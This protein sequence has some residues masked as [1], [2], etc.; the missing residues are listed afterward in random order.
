[1]LTKSTMKFIHIILIAFLSFFS[2]QLN[3]Q[4]LKGKIQNANNQPVEAAYIY[5]IN[6]TSHSHSSE[7]GV[8]VLENTRVGDSIKVGILGYE[9]RIITL[10]TSSFES[11]FVITLQEKIFQLDEMVLT[12]QI[13]PVSTITRLDLNTNPINSSQVA[14]RRVPG[15]IIGQHAGGGKAEQ[16]FLRGFDIDHGTD[17]S[18]TVDGMPVNMVSH[19]H[20]QGYSDL[21]FLIPETVNKIDFGNGPH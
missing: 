14:L 18:L 15:L 5:N 19:A 2:L 8:F 12:E 6:S 21:H 11:D 3:A 16:I 4:Q 1:S 20:G 10:E 9:T 17:V 7:I 13:N